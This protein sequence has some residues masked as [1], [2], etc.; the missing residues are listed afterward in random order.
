MKTNPGRL[1]EIVSHK[2]YLLLALLVLANLA[3]TVGD[4]ELW[5]INPDDRDCD[6]APDLEF[7]PAAFVTVAPGQ[8]AH[9]IARSSETILK[10]RP[11]DTPNWFT[12]QITRKGSDSADVKFSPTDKL[13]SDVEGQKRTVSILA[14][15]KHMTLKGH[16]YVIASGLPFLAFDS[17]PLIMKSGSTLGTRAFVASPGPDPWTFKIVSM[18]SGLTVE[19]QQADTSSFFITLKSKTFPAGSGTQE[20]WM[21]I[22]ASAGPDIGSTT[23][24]LWVLVISD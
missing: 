22:K 4:P 19:D 18:S 21:I 11:G 23:E 17:N 14:D 20:E 7:A 2:L 1:Q 10:R 6:S 15:A 5:K 8:P 12:V 9:L 3:G 13:T 24:R 16:V